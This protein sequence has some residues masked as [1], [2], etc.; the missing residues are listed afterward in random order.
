M[1][2]TVNGE[3]RSFDG[4]LDVAGLIA[5][6][7]LEPRKVAIERN[8]EIVPKSLYA[9]TTLTENDTIEIVHFVGGG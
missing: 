7:G 4:P 1:R 5:A 6:L 2:V 3:A 8:R 9:V